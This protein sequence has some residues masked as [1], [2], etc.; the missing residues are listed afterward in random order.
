MVDKLPYLSQN[1]CL[2]C[3]VSCYF[4]ECCYSWS[5]FRSVALAV[6]NESRR[7]IPLSSSGVEWRRR[8]RE[9]SQGTLPT[10]LERPQT[11]HCAVCLTLSFPVDPQ[12]KIEILTTFFFSTKSHCTNSGLSDLRMLHFE[13]KLSGTLCPTS[14]GNRI[15]P[16]ISEL[17]DLL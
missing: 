7:K 16:R 4:Y 13:S 5:L 11:W 3:I 6:R 14:C 1:A 9:R 8:W 15:S 2:T 17:E 12:P 10:Y